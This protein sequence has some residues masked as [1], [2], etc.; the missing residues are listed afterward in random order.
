MWNYYRDEPKSLPF[1]NDDPPT[2]NY[3]ADPITNSASF[4]YKTSVIGKTPD[5]DNDNNNNN[6][7]EKVEIAV[8][9]K[10]LGSFW[11]NLNI[12]LV[13]CEINVIFMWSKSSVLTNI[14]ITAAADTA[15]P[16]VVA[17]NAPTNATLAITDCKFQV[18]VTSPSTENYNKLLEQLKTGFKRTIK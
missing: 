12:P 1:N 9:L 13:K 15:D 3:N 10:Y 14:I 6:V 7:I 8:P 18:P 4:K 2:A 17:I 16:P 5:N 11:R